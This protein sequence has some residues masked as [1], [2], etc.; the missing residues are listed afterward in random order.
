LFYVKLFVPFQ[1]ISY[2]H[3]MIG[4]KTVIIKEDLV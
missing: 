1:P 2:I 4:R 3:Y